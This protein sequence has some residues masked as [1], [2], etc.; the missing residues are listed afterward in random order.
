MSDLSLQHRS[1]AMA[2]PRVFSLPHY[3]LALGFLGFYVLLDWIS[4]I[5]P[6]APFGITPWNPP[7]GLS[8]ILVLLFGQRFI[9]LLFVAPLLADLLVRQLPLPWSVE[10]ATSLIIG[11]GYARRADGVVASVKRVSIRR[12]PR[13]AIC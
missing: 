3:V 6:F 2:F 5:Q 1:V 12:L 10:I 9:P 7:T 11:G 13:C 8:F 4:F